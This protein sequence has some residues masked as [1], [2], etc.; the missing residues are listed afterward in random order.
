MDQPFEPSDWG[1]SNH[2]AGVEGS[3]SRQSFDQCRSFADAPP[4]TMLDYDVQSSPLDW[5]LGSSSAT[6]SRN[7]SNSST[8]HLDL[9]AAIDIFDDMQDICSFSTPPYPA[10]SLDRTCMPG[11]GLDNLPTIHQKTLALLG[12]SSPPAI[13]AASFGTY[14]ADNMCN[15]PI[16][17]PVVTEAVVS[18]SSSA[19][20]HG[21]VSNKR[22]A[23]ILDRRI[24]RR[25]PQQYLHHV[26]QLQTAR[27][28]AGSID[29]SYTTSILEPPDPPGP[30][31]EACR[32]WL[33]NH[34]GQ[35]PSE[36]VILGIHLAFDAT[37]E[38]LQHWFEKHQ[39]GDSSSYRM[40]DNDVTSP[41]RDNRNKCNKLDGTYHAS[42]S[43]INI[44]RDEQRPYACTSRCGATFKAKDDWR[45]HEEI[46]YPQ[47]LWYCRLSGCISR[48]LG[49][50]VSF[51]K[52]HFITHR[53]QVHGLRDTDPKDINACCLPIASRFPQECL[54]QNC[55][56]VFETWKERTNHL[57]KHFVRPWDVSEWRHLDNDAVCISDDKEDV[58]NTRSTNL[59][60]PNGKC[61]TTEPHSD[62]DDD[63]GNDDRGFQ[64]SLGRRS[65]FSTWSAMGSGSRFK[66]DGSGSNNK[67]IRHQKPQSRSSQGSEYICNV[68]TGHKSQNILLPQQC[69]FDV[70]TDFPPVS[71]DPPSVAHIKI[72]HVNLDFLHQ[73]LSLIGSTT[74]VPH[75]SSP[76]AELVVLENR[77]DQSESYTGQVATVKGW[78]A[79]LPETN[80]RDTSH[81]CG[82][83]PT[84]FETPIDT[85][86]EDKPSA[87]G[88][89]EYRGPQLC[90]S[91][92]PVLTMKTGE[93]CGKTGPILG[94]HSISNALRDALLLKEYT[95]HDYDQKT[96]SNKDGKED[97]PY[98]LPSPTPISPNFLQIPTIVTRPSTENRR[99]TTSSAGK[100]PSV[101]DAYSKAS[102][103]EVNPTRIKC[104]ESIFSTS[105]ESGNKDPPSETERRASTT[106]PNKTRLLPPSSFD[107]SMALQ[108]SPL[109]IQISPLESLITIPGL[110]SA[111]S[112]RMSSLSAYESTAQR[113]TRWLRPPMYSDTIFCETSNEAVMAHAEASQNAPSVRKVGCVSPSTIYV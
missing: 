65:D 51:R 84:R 41:Y 55:A 94:D 57:A 61:S 109:D 66:S 68:G 31:I 96:N 99:V 104:T 25:T 6:D 59:G 71:N 26:R 67:E 77:A 56:K 11:H 20:P 32:L 12:N 3:N 7:S 1:F 53:A 24:D 27:T 102:P 14:G 29:P 54:F 64:G 98:E 92:S 110:G 5:M 86:S 90:Y 28:S 81:S 15:G 19:S 69:R 34:P 36:M 16:I 18:K 101:L 93:E 85:L 17:D 4:P 82:E 58:N 45:K 39:S 83:V 40:A 46:N 108:L 8:T 30:A 78:L 75:P 72:P 44:Y 80:P 88:P 22:K 89:I 13:A 63:D 74:R 97:I 95:D 100:K 38:L 107:S 73:L 9:P 35:T 52:E 33:A 21:R 48:S 42:Q 76:R 60:D 43:S 87:P 113:L 2:Y 47:K 62:Y 105:N 70:S 50:R 49:Q 23:K 103:L 79:K 106:A 10:D 112:L 91:P 111:M 37:R